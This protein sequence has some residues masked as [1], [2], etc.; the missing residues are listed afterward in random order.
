MVVL[1]IGYALHLGA[2]TVIPFLNTQSY[3]YS[4]PKEEALDAAEP[5]NGSHRS[6]GHRYRYNL[7]HCGYEKVVL[8]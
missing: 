5:A 7:T 8:F 1:I 4:I 2:R 6:Q 3:F